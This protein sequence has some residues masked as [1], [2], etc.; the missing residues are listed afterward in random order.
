MSDEKK[1]RVTANV[2]ILSDRL[3]GQAKELSD[4]MRSC[5]SSINVLGIATNSQ[6]VMLLA[7][8]QSVDFLII[9]GYLRNESSYGVIGDLF[10]Q[11]KNYVPVH[12]AMLDSLIF[13]LCQKYK[14]PLMFDRTLPKAD[15]IDYL[16]NT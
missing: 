11:Q 1:Q 15:F 12:W 2:I 7:K 4:Y 10:E 16:K 9:A 8:N 14:I 6:E 13:A 5:T 3:M